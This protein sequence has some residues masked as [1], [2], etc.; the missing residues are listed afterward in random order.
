MLMAITILAA[1]ADLTADTPP[2]EPP[3]DAA[4]VRALP[5]VEHGVLFVYQESRDNFVIVKNHLSRCTVPVPLFVGGS[6]NMLKD[7]WEC[8]AYYE[9]VIESDFPFPLQIRKQAVSVVYIDQLKPA[10]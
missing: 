3:S 4:V 10:K 7:R 6:V 5:R 8:V 9:R 2:R 1:L